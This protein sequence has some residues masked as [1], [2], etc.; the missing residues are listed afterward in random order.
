MTVSVKFGSRVLAV[1]VLLA[2]AGTTAAALAPRA[3]SSD[4]QRAHPARKAKPKPVAA[5]PAP[6]PAAPLRVSYEGGLL[7][8]SAQ[9]APLSDILAQ[10]H[11]RTGATIDAPADMHERIVVELGP[12]P[13]AQVVA[14][15]LEATH[16]NYLIVGAAN[17]PGAV[18]SI[19]LTVQPSFVAATETPDGNRPAAPP[20]STKANLTGDDEGVWDDV[21]VPAATPAPPADTAA[22]PPQ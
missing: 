2:C 4:H 11:Q 3:V 10:L 12:G 13:A 1:F 5:V 19:Q 17:K 14:A 16:F 9:D 15:L 18:Q 20:A 8:I 6:P 22:R 21:E 7:S